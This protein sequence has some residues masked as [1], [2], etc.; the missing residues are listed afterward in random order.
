MELHFSRWLLL[1]CAFTITMVFLP[2]MCFYFYIR[3]LL[4]L[5]W[6]AFTFTRYAFTFG[7]LNG[8]GNSSSLSPRETLDTVE[9]WISFNNF[10][11]CFFIVLSLLM[12]LS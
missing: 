6:C 11:I 9:V 3:M 7:V 4:L 8:V 2:L 10:K 12:I 5:L 1:F